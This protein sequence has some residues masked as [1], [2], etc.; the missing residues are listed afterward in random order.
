MLFARVVVD[1][2]FWRTLSKKLDQQLDGCWAVLR[3]RVD[4]DPDLHFGCRI[5]TRLFTLTRNGSG[6]DFSP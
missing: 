2:I 6:F 3:I 4:A 5:R 1:S